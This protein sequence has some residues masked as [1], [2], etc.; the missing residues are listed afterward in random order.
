LELHSSANMFDFSRTE[1][2]GYQGDIFI[3]L[4]GSLPP[5]TGAT[6]LIGYKISRIDRKTGVV[7]DFITHVAPGNTQAIIFA[8]DGTNCSNSFNK[9]IDVRFRGTEMFI[10]DMGVGAGATT[11]IPNSG[12]VWKVTRVGSH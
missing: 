10:V 2:F 12:K 6:T 5:G 8:C 7:S 3:A 11:Q 4:T 1:A 9:P